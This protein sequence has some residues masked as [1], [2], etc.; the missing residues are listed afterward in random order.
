MPGWRERSAYIARHG[1]I[2]FFHY[3]FYSQALAKIERGHDRDQR[4]VEQM[5]ETGLVRRKKLAECF[6]QIRPSLVRFPAIDS[7]TF[8]GRVSAIIRP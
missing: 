8:A 3:D 4:D 6:E 7:A 1:Q 2:D 5:L